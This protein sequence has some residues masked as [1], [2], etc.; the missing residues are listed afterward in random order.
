M[1]RTRVL[2]TGADSLIGSHIQNILLSDRA[3]SLRAVITTSERASEIQQEFTQAG[4]SPDVVVLQGQLVAGSS[5][6][7]EPLRDDSDPFHIV[8]HTSTGNPTHQVDCL[9][10]F[11]NLEAES[12]IDFLESIQE[13][14]QRV[15]RVVIVNSLAP[16]AEWLVKEADASRLQSVAAVVDTEYI[17]AA[18]Q[19]GNNIVHN[20]VLKWL[21][22]FE[23]RFDVVFV[24]SPSC[25]GPATRPLETSS[26]VLDANRRIWNICNNE[27]DKV[28]ETTPFGIAPFADVRDVALACVRIIHRM[29]VANKHFMIC[30]GVMPSD[31]RIAEFL[32]AQFPQSRGRLMHEQSSSHETQAEEFPMEM[33][34]MTAVAMLGLP[35][36]RSIQETLT[37]TTQ[38]ML[39]LQHRKEWRRII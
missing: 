2:L 30:G 35:A 26:D 10:R 32:H 15:R 9:A 36:Y 6:Y 21:T 29:H 12:L 17:L 24:T 23:P 8:L 39:D 25:Y 20:T 38:Q 14:A 37:D 31:R 27:W 33:D 13:Y 22:H 34:S 3:I 19:A 5:A 4:S 18:S 28:M 7:D 1:S 16:F 11:I